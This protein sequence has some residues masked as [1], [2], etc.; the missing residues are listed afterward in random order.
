MRNEL[1]KLKEL[2]ERLQKPKTFED[3]TQIT[4]QTLLQGFQVQQNQIE[5]LKNRVEK[6]E[7]ERNQPFK[8][9]GIIC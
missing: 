8:I 1:N 6:L 7:A 9:D 4:M 3:L 2:K 5:E